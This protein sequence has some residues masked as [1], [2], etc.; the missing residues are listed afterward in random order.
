MNRRTVRNS[1]PYGWVLFAQSILIMQLG[2]S[3]D[4]LAVTLVGAIPLI[5]SYH[6]FTR[7]SL[8]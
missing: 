5:F 3:A 8:H 7:G 4:N 1:A 6:V 2:V